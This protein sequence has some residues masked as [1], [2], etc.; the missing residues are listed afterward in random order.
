MKQK[1]ALEAISAFPEMGLMYDFL[2]KYE[3]F[4]QYTENL[5][6]YIIM[7]RV[8]TASLQE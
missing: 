7:A 4:T 1:Q 6:P 3:K 2:K 5:P 8:A